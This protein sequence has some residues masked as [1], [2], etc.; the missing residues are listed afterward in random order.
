M[1]SSGPDERTKAELEWIRFREDTLGDD[2]FPTETTSS[3]FNRKVKENPLVPIGKLLKH[4]N[5]TIT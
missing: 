2:A 5:K 1:G 4:L 3:K